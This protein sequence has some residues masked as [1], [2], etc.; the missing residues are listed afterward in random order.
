[1]PWCSSGG[2]GDDDRADAAAAAA[3][4]A[5][6]A[7][8]AAAVA[9]LLLPPPPPPRGLGVEGAVTGPAGPRRTGLGRACQPVSRAPARAYFRVVRVAD[10]GLRKAWPVWTCPAGRVCLFLPVCLTSLFDQSL[11]SFRDLNRFMKI[12]SSSSSSPP[13]LFR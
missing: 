10:S 4:A 5:A 8:A 9:M 2:G 6:I 11:L 13:L 12:L 1:M 7:A 3:V